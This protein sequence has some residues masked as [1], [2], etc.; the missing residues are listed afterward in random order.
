[1]E[2]TPD[3]PQ[4]SHIP[5]H[6][7]SL[8]ST[9][10]TADGAGGREVHASADDERLLSS[11]TSQQP[12]PNQP[13]QGGT[14]HGPGPQPQLRHSTRSHT[15]VH[16]GHQLQMLWAAHCVMV[17]GWWC[18]CGR[19]PP[20]ASNQQQQQPMHTQK[21]KGTCKEKRT[22]KYPDAHEAPQNMCLF[23]SSVPAA[24]S[25]LQCSFLSS[26]RFSHIPREDGSLTIVHLQFREKNITQAGHTTV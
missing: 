14:V 20:T 21:R 3:L 2:P 18:C 1:M 12:S 19:R 9:L 23:T 7:S 25:A 10:P 13:K 16:W 15:K 17:V 8:T 5:C 22:C 26:R 6:R 11:Q 4:R 24:T